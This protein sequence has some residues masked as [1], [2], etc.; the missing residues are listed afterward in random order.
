V[1]VDTSALLACFNA[2]ETAHAAMTTALEA[3]TEDLIV[4]PYVVA[5]VDYLIASRFGV[6]AELAALEELARGAWI[7]APFSHVDLAAAARVVQRY[8]DQSIG[9]T[10]ASIVVLADSCRTRTVATL[11]RRHFE[12]LRP[13]QGGRFRIVPE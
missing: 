11:D 9:M 7:L 8:S 4:S 5:E 13:L 12:V 10:D 1:I 2:D 3:T 6:T